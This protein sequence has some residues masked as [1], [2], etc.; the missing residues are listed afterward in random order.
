MKSFSL[1]T[2]SWKSMLEIGLRYSL[3]YLLCASLSASLERQIITGVC[4]IQNLT[5]ILTQIFTLVTELPSFFRL[6]I[7]NLKKSNDFVMAYL[8]KNGEK[9]LSQT[10]C[11]IKVWDLCVLQ[12]SQYLGISVGEPFT[13]SLQYKY[14]SRNIW[15]FWHLG[16]TWLLQHL[17]FK[18]S[19]C[20]KF[21]PKHDTIIWVLAKMSKGFFWWKLHVKVS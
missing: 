20:G 13:W 12:K 8:R 6:A 11:K 18:I 3:L 2:L 10:S 21:N 16:L 7:L 1:T 19:N 9:I 5:P 15:L 17:I 4:V 14:L